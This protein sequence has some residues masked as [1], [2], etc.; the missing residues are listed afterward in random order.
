M[1]IITTNNLKHNIYKWFIC[2][3]MK[4]TVA[5][6]CLMMYPRAVLIKLKINFPKR[7]SKT[8]K[9]LNRK[10]IIMIMILKHNLHKLYKR[11]KSI[12]YSER[13]KKSHQDNPQEW[14]WWLRKIL[15]LINNLL[16]LP[17]F[18]KQEILNKLVINL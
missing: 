11:M 15:I 4:M 18:S 7:K 6:H 13:V 3:Q 1:M 2:H 12:S 9:F 14:Q 17:E 10:I 5:L 16:N 8:W